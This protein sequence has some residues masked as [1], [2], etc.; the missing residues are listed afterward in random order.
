MFK[1]GDVVIYGLQGICRI[2]CIEPKKIGKQVMDYYVLKPVFNENT[3]VFVPINNDVLTSKMKSVLTKSQIEILLK[4]AADIDTINIQDEN[5]KREIYKK[6]L[7][8]GD[9]ERLIALIKTIHT[10]RDIRRQDNKKLNMNDEQTL[11]K[12]E[13]ILYNEIAFVYGVE[14]DDIINI[15]KF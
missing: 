1:V 15:I 6:I 5:Q 9:R 3:S 10:Q 2:D 7:S 11:R 13:D 14:L 12:A 4:K 8:G